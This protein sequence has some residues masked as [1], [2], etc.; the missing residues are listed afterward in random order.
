MA[1]GAPPSG[2]LAPGGAFVSVFERV[3]GWLETGVIVVRFRTRHSAESHSTCL[4]YGVGA[5]V[6]DVA[7][8]YVAE[9][10][11]GHPGGAGRDRGGVDETP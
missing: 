9:Q 10:G 8:Y 2:S 6:V 1:G 4:Y 5:D 7:V 3:T 11:E